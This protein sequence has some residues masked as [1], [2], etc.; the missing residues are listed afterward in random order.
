VKNNILC[1]KCY[2]SNIL[3]VRERKWNWKYNHYH[4]S[5]CGAVDKLE[6]DPLKIRNIKIEKI[7]KKLW[8]NQ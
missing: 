6:Q 8:M 1:A 7:M 5:D 4:C 3:I 2:S